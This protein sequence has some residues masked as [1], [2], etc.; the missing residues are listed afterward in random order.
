MS[1]LSGSYPCPFHR[2][3]VLLTTSQRVALLNAWK[4]FES[5]HGSPSDIEK[6]DKQM[7]RKVK[8]RR[9]L[10]DDSFEEYMDYVF[11][12]D[13]E[14]AAKMSKLLQMAHQWKQTQGE[15]GVA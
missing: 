11:P 1:P 10:D 14:S 15:N 13:D 12:A 9:K 4:S 8:K 3:S 6:V 7:P 5:T 2:L